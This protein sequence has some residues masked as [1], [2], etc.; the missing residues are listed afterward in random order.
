M[1]DICPIGTLSTYFAFKSFRMMSGSISPSKVSDCELVG[2]IMVISV[3]L[4]MLLLTL[5]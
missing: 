3:S 2:G 1:S 4:I 5:F